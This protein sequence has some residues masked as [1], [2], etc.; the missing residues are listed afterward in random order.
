MQMNALEV[1]GPQQTT[2]QARLIFAR[3][4][5]FAFY[6]RCNPCGRKKRLSI[7]KAGVAHLGLLSLESLAALGLPQMI[8]KTFPLQ[9]QVETGGRIC[10]IH[11][12]N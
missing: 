2:H 7:Q 9:G 11:L 6:G 8:Y 10:R 4:V 3:T 1:A 5:P 12:L